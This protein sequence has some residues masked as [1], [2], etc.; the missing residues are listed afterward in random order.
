MGE[1]FSRNSSHDSFDE[2]RV[3]NV[4]VKYAEETVRKVVVQ[5]R[6]RALDCQP[7]CL[8]RYRSGVILRSNAS[9]YYFLVLLWSDF[10]DAFT[11]TRMVIA[12]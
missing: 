9:E 4:Q 6:Q 7:C 3:E 5:P 12:C 2:T 8:R 1:C 10:L 11:M